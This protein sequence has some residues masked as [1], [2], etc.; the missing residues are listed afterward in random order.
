[1][2]PDTE[3]PRTERRGAGLPGGADAAAWALADAAGR[4]LAEATV[5]TLRTRE[6]VAEL[7][8]R[9]ANTGTAQRAGHLFE[10]MH[11]LSFNQD[12][13]AQ[14]SSLRAVVTEWA[15][16]GSQTA[17]A[18]LHIVKGGRVVAQA[19]AKLTGRAPSA[20][21]ALAQSKYE[22]MQRLVASDR[23][24][25]VED[26]L[27]RR[28]SMSPEGLRYEDYRDARAHVGDRL[29]AGGV[30][31]RGVAYEEAQRAARAPKRWADEQVVKA[32]AR[33][34]A[35]S[36]VTAATVGGL[37][38]GIGTA[39][40]EAARVRAGETSA[41]V[42]AATALASAVRGAA[43]SGVV[44]GLGET[45]RVAADAG[46]LPHALGGGTLPFA[47]SG[48]VYAT[49][50]AGLDLAR[51]RIGAGEFAARACETTLTSALV[52]GCGVVGQSV[53]PVPVVG[54]LVGGLAGQ[55]AGFVIVQGMQLALVAARASHT[56]A[57]RLDL[58]ER[59]I[60]T[61]VLV[62]RELRQATERLGAERNA[63]ATGVVL[64]RFERVQTALAEGRPGPALAEL[65][66]LTRDFGGT[67]VCG[68]VEEFDQWMADE[69]RVLSLNPNW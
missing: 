2:S 14:G 52:W 13:I 15:P 23:R 69:S 7:A 19:Q 48:A 25:A 54:A 5:E 4:R 31:S 18:D 28:L 46:V 51:G 58:L 38:S 35:V 8:A 6:V 27:D 47:V 59:E 40:A 60:I 17:P 3:R 1:M 29:S 45:I 20:A 42:A 62:L 10:V 11:A 57:E 26:L 61:S 16:G 50:E 65:A 43:R 37:V 63:Y 44:A 64:P 32:G 12:A 36:A 55:A 33:Q 39:A 67:P 49:A 53:I 9:Y 22:G 68:T 34:V 56:D 66:E 21:H 24:Q 30:R 41:S